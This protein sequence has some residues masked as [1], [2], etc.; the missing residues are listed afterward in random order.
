MLGLD[1]NE[2]SNISLNVFPLVK[3]FQE[4]NDTENEVICHN[5]KKTREFPFLIKKTIKK[6]RL[7]EKSIEKKNK[8]VLRKN[9]KYHL[10]ST[11]NISK[12]SN[13]INFINYSKINTNKKKRRYIREKNLDKLYATNSIFI[14][15]NQFNQKSNKYKKNFSAKDFPK[16]IDT[17]K[18]YITLNK[19]KSNI[20][21]SIKN[22]ISYSN[23]EKNSTFNIKCGI[24]NNDINSFSY[25]PFE[26]TDNLMNRN[27]KYLNIT[28]NICEFSE[29]EKNLIFNKENKINNDNIHLTFHSTEMEERNFDYF[30]LKI[31]EKN[32]FYSERLEIIQNYLCSKKD[33]ISNDNYIKNNCSHF[34]LTKVKKNS[35][36]DEINED[37]FKDKKKIIKDESKY[38]ID[39]YKR[40]SDE[41]IPYYC[42][43][44]NCNKN[45]SNKD[46]WENHY[47][48]H[49]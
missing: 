27:P 4:K 10:S 15:K 32:E 34:K 45:F 46:E 37:C 43:F 6:N 24:S 39:D 14:Q 29:N 41:I 19:L 48:K 11:T 42:V 16:Q 8:Y 7:Q 47:E 35:C 12:E 30:D 40:Y 44:S 20:S 2:I 21:N 26:K 3:M 18:N 5:I 36:V 22:D 49:Y 13:K 9:C 23:K 38:K 17:K 31:F 33:K 25:F 28:K 1:I